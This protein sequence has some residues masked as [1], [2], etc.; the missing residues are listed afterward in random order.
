M[1]ELK[2]LQSFIGSELREF[3]KRFRLS[4]KSNVSLLDRIS[5]YIV[6]RKGKQVRPMF[7][8]L[9]A[10]LVSQVR[11]ETYVAASLIELL[12]TASLVHD[13]VVD[14]SYMRRSVFSINA[15]WK[16]KIAVLV[17]DYLLSKGLHLA[18]ENEQFDLLRIVSQAVKELSEGELL[19]ME[20]SRNSRIT[21][22]LYYKII[23]QKTASLIAA[24]CAAGMRSV[25]S[26]KRRVD[27]MLEFGYLAGMAFQIKDDLFDFELNDVGKPTG[28]NLTDKKITLPL[29]YTLDNLSKSERSKLSSLIRKSSDDRTSRNQI[30]DAVST[31]GGI[32]YSIKKMT[33]FKE[34]AI[35]ILAHFEDSPSK[36]TLISLVEFVVNRKK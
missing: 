28:I 11:D 24:S 23:R 7:V 22:E 17:G 15:L 5:Y 26:D 30:I 31:S 3:E 27:Q 25:T 29:I 13:D 14:D 34:K 35:A 8:F 9:S 20:K 4:M 2:K 21:E 10:R 18:V 19:Q 36:E 33:E 16:N 32:D 6:Q 12:H 1:P